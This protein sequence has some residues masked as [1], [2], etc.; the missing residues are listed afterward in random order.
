MF[1]LILAQ[2]AIWQPVQ[3]P[4]LHQGHWTSCEGAERVLEHRV[5]GR[6]AFELHMGP[7][8]EFAL[9]SGYGPD[10]PEHTHD[11]A[12]NL[13]GAPE[14]DS[15]ETWHGARQWGV[16]SLGLWLSIIRGGETKP[17]CDAF[18]IRIERKQ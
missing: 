14:H 9:Y 2:L 6:V 12:D 10:G 18:F 5:G 15:L 1:L 17:G 4:V 7:G 13:L 3:P 16:A 8:A 11:G